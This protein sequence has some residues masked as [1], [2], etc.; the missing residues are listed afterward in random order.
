MDKTTCEDLCKTLN[1]LGDAPLPKG[2]KLRLEL[3][4]LD[5]GDIAIGKTKLPSM[6]EQESLILA[7]IAVRKLG[8]SLMANVVDAFPNEGKH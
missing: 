8:D 4:V 6:R 1:S 2:V 3:M 7:L 5:S